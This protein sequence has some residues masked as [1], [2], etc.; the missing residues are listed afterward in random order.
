MDN[1]PMD[2]NPTQL[3]TDRETIRLTADG[4]FLSDGQEITHERTATAFH[5][6]LGHD[7]VG[8]FIQIGRDFKR[9]EVEDTAHF[10]RAVNWVSEKKIELKLMDGT[11]EVLNP[12]T[13]R[14]SEKRLTCLIKDGKEEAKFLR[15]PY[16]E[17]F[18]KAQVREESGKYHAVI[19]GK[20]Y[21][22][23]P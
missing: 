12:E 10:V 3:F 1:I 2:A 13:L 9:I 15:A 6:H 5:K 8:Y 14:F 23:K 21:D 7:E 11:T 17:F 19:A 16:L 22:L 18:L 4:V 20:K